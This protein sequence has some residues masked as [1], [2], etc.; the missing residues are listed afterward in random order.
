MKDERYIEIEKYEYEF[1][2]LVELNLNLKLERMSTSASS[3]INGQISFNAHIPTKNSKLKGTN[4]FYSSSKKIIHFTSLQILFSIINEGAL[5]L[6][7]M[8]KSNDNEEYSF[9]AKTLADVY[10]LQGINFNKYIDK[11]KEYSFILSST[12][13]CG[14]KK[15]NFWGKYGDNKKGVAIEFEI[16]N[17]LESWEYFYLSKVHYDKIEVFE[18]LNKEWKSL[19]SKNPHLNYQI[20]LHQLLSLHKSSDWD[21]EDEIR[22]LTLFPDSFC[23]SEFNER[24]FSDF[25]P[26]KPNG[27]IKYFKLPLCD[28]NG[29]FIEK[30]L[31]ERKGPFWSIIPRIR[32][33]DIYFGSDFP[34]KEDF[35][36]YQDYLKNYIAKKMNIWL[37]NLPKNKV[38]IE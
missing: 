10:K 17:T 31:N 35:Y 38:I 36:K 23:T 24:I 21:D 27:K 25:I 8:H 9:A 11:I 14:L 32:I 20:K 12:S 28:K 16:I 30:E 19:Q 2:K 37:A 33:S 15:D 26:S 13:N 4:Y 3:M 29:N 6:Y 22:L 5:R 1:W 18:K 34:I 7:N